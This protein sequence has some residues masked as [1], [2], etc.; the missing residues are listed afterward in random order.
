M[1]SVCTG[2]LVYTAA[3]LLDDGP[4]T[5]HWSAIERLLQ[6]G[7]NIEARPDARSSPHPESP[8]A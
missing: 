1:T 7:S 4:A 3:G 8:P 5:T 2:S 6:L